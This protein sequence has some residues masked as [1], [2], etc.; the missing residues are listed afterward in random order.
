VS[1]ADWAVVTPTSATE[2]P[3]AFLLQ[4]S[5]NTGATRSGGV[6]V[7]DQT[8]PIAQEGP[9]SAQIPGMQ[10]FSPVVST[11]ASQTFTFQ[12]ADPN[13]W[14]DLGVVNVLINDYLDGRHACYLA[15]SRPLNVCT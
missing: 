1:A 8:I 15:Y 14:Q 12:F 13:G 9:A 2:G 4:L 11:G 7:G 5:A 6:S 3:G 10:T